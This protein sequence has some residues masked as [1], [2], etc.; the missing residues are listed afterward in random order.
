MYVLYIACVYII[1]NVYIT[2]SSVQSSMFIQCGCE[3]VQ[4]KREQRVY[5]VF[6]IV[7][8]FVFEYQNFN[9]FLL[10]CIVVFVFVWL[11]VCLAMCN[12]AAALKNS[13]T[14]LYGKNQTSISYPEPLLI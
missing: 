8:V 5:S 4:W 7:F 3:C 10:F 9:S 2:L 14:L 11:V 1:N 13:I 6:D 12:K